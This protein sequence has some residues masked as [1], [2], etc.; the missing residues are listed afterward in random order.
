MSDHEMSDNDQEEI[1][2]LDTDSRLSDSPGCETDPRSNCSSPGSHEN[3]GQ[4]TP[5]TALPFSISNLLGKNFEK[6]QET[7]FLYQPS[8]FPRLGVPDSLYQSAGVLRVPAHRPLGGA[9]TP[10]FNNPWTIGIDPV[11][12]RSA[13]AAF[14]SQVL[15]DRLSGNFFFQYLGPKSFKGAGLQ[16]LDTILKFFSGVH[17]TLF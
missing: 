1:N 15:K 16:S 14:T 6:S 9:T 11:L 7:Q 17:V 10:I 8:V 12:Q 4:T 3:V 13:A 5:K 2:V